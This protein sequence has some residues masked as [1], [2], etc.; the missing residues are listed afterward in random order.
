MIIIPS[1]RDGK[2]LV[3]AVSRVPVLEGAV[4]KPLQSAAE[5]CLTE[6]QMAE[7]QILAIVTKNREKVG[8][9]ANLLC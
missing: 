9:R 8:V 5:K 1:E 6:D 2:A 3:E 7:K 4:R